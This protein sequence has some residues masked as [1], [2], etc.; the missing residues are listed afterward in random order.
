MFEGLDRRCQVVTGV[1][2]GT[3]ERRGGESPIIS[4]SDP[5]TATQHMQFD[6]GR[7][8]SQTLKTAT[9]FNG[10]VQARQGV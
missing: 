7:Q 1:S 2:G 9:A 8:R 3:G 4:Q 6:G 5:G 10:D